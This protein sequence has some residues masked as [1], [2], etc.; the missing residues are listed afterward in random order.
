MRLRLA[1]G[2]LGF[3]DR[4]HRTRVD[5]VKIFTLTPV[6]TDLISQRLS[7]NFCTKEEKHTIVHEVDSEEK[8]TSSLLPVC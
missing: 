2:M 6:S 7:T 5:P 3:Q 4:L 8:S 1:G